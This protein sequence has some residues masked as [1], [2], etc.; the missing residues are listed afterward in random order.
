M[1]TKIQLAQMNENDLRVK[2]IIPLLKAM[3]FLDVFEYHGGSL[4]QGKD[5]VF[6]KPDELKSRVNYAIVAKATDITGKAEVRPGTAGEVYMQ[7]QQCFGQSFRDSVSGA[8]ENVHH[9]WIITNKRILKEAEQSICASLAIN[10][11]KNNVR[12]IDGNLLWELIEEHLPVRSAFQK[13]EEVQ[14]VFASLDSHYRLALSEIDGPEVQF[15]LVEQFTGASKEKPLHFKP[16]FKF[17]HTTEGIAAKEALI[18]SISTGVPI[19]IPGEFVANFEQPEFLE[20]LFGDLKIQSM[21][22]QGFPIAEHAL[23]VHLEFENIYHN[24]CLVEYVELKLI[25]SSRDELI[26]TNDDQKIPLKVRLKLSPTTRKLDLNFTYKRLSNNVYQIYREFEFLNCVYYPFKLRLISGMDGIIFFEQQSTSGI[27]DPPNP[28]QLEFF[29]NLNLI[30]SKLKQKLDFPERDLTDLEL[31]IIAKLH[32]ILREASLVAILKTPAVISVPFQDA[33][34]LFNKYARGEPVDLTL[35]EEDQTMELF[36][37]ILRLGRVRHS[38]SNLRLIDINE[39]A[40]RIDNTLDSKSEIEIH[41]ES[42]EQTIGIS[43]FLDWVKD[44]HTH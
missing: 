13:I 43:K 17:P 27:S 15:K 35:Y 23:L 16:T 41:F 12:F 37:T 9:C 3:K 38:I 20:L 25:H 42:H 24:N 28:R 22:M 19:D 39:L 8:T 33:K 1:L 36:G 5:V 18:R 32:V 4:E 14:K 2:V 6:W 29:Q 7:I 34:E 44:E 30:Q 11:L 21:S 10:H 26:Y 31:E 40:H